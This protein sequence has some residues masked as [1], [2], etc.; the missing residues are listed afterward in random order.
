MTDPT[1][2]LVRHL[3]DVPDEEWSD[4]SRGGASWR[5]LFSADVT[6]TSALTTGVSSVPTGQALVRHRHVAVE[7]YFFIE[8]HGVLTLG[9]DAYPVRAGSAVHIP[10]LTPHGVRNAG[11]TTLRFFYAFATDSFEDVAYDFVEHPG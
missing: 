11:P 8:G 10:S 6:P 1:S 5:T 3:D 9:H 2:P 7:T 4:P